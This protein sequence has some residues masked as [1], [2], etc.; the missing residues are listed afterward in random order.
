MACTKRLCG[1]VPNIGKQ[2]LAVLVFTVIRK[3]TFRTDDHFTYAF[4]YLQKNHPLTQLRLPGTSPSPGPQPP[5]SQ[6]SPPMLWC[7]HYAHTSCSH[8]A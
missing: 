4:F 1:S 3:T 5:V 8:R 2:P 6:A 7:I